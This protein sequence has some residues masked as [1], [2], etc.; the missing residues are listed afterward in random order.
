MDDQQYKFDEDEAVKFIRAELP[1]DISQKYDDDE[2]LSIIDIIWDY[3]E[4][5]GFLSLNL[6]ETDEEVLDVDDLVQYVKK[7]VKND[8]ELIMDPKDVELIVK[9]ELDYEE[10]LE[11][12]V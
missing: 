4:R 12:Y 1:A 7:E 8:K 2:I 10:S 3:Y 9:A 6:L 5:K 11:D